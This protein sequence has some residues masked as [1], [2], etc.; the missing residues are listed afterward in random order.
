MNVQEAQ[1]SLLM[2]IS[3][4]NTTNAFNKKYAKSDLMIFI[5]TFNFSSW[6]PFMDEW[7]HY[8]SSCLS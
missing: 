3:A 7:P 1:T 4:Y 6:I 2:G 5:L 8:T